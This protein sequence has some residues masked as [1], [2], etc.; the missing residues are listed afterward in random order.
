MIFIAGGRGLEIGVDTHTYLEIYN[1]IGS[2]GYLLYLEPGWNYINIISHDF[3]ISFNGMLIITSCL[4]LLP[5]FYL[6]R[7]LSYNQYIPIFIYF[8]LHIYGASFNVMRQYAAVTYVLLTYFCFS[9]KKWLWMFLW[10]AIA[11][12]LHKSTILVVPIL[13]VLK[14]IHLDNSKF[15]GFCL[16]CAFALGFIMN[17]DFFRFFIMDYTSYIENG[18]YRESSITATF[19]SLLV[20]GFSYWLYTLLPVNDRNNIWCKLFILSLFILLLTY[21]LEYGARIYIMGS[22]SQLFFI[23]YLLKT[24]K[25]VKSSQLK[26]IIFSYYAVIFFRMWLLNANDIMPYKNVLI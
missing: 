1:D 21:K 13:I 19:F 9:K 15:V 14:Y 17:D 8:A 12:N 7:K 25:K 18:L 5:V 22:I 26:I 10:L 20:S 23:P 11:I 24:Q 16:L 6:A 2:K 4:T 3:G